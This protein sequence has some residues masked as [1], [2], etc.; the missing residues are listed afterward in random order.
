MKGEYIIGVLFMDKQKILELTGRLILATSK[1]QIDEIY[2]I[3]QELAKVIQQ[4]KQGDNI[5]P[6]EEKQIEMN[7]T[8]FL[9]FTNKEIL[10]MPKTLRNSFRADGAVIYYRKR[11]RSKKSISY[12]ARYRRHGYN[13]SRT[14]PTLDLLK[15]KILEALKN[16]DKQPISNVPTT[17]TAFSDYYFEKYYKRR[18][19]P[20][21]Y[22]SQINRFNLYL[23]PLFNSIALSKITPFECQK[24]FDNL[25]EQGKNKTAAELKSILNGIFDTAKRHNLIVNN[26]IDIV[27]LN[28]YDKEHGKALSKD[29]EK[30]LLEA[31]ANTA[32]Q[33]MF[34]VA[35]YTGLRPN[36]YKTAKIEGKFVIAVNSKR[37]TNKIDYKKIPITKKLAPFLVGITELKFF[38]TNRIGEKFR[39]ILPN[40]K[41]YDLRTTFYT[42]CQECGVA[43]VAIKKFVGHS[44][45]G[46]AE[47]YTDLSDE[48]LLKEAEKIDY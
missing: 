14:A 16:A 15:D 45:N 25:A 39:K 29:E 2:I 22:S 46:L 10:E 31:T 7:L 11:I 44:L 18:V 43:E 26:P 21:T 12:E 42:R 19:S 20:K 23:K 47:T 28:H 33:L 17:F 38:G 35:L 41:L 34:A 36:E 1:Q 40:H 30:R 8:G 3:F 48:F 32:Y 27:I 5:S 9:K 24:L 37:K 6:C 13:I 4:M